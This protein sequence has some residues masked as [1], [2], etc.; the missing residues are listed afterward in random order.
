VGK[1]RGY[2][3]ETHSLSKVSLAEMVRCPNQNL[4]ILLK[5]QNTGLLRFEDL[6]VTSQAIAPGTGN[7]VG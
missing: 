1:W 5:R 3:F 6:P 2:Q 7:I 4:R